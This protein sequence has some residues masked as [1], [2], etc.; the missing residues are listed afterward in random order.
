MLYFPSQQSPHVQSNRKAL[1]PYRYQFPFFTLLSSGHCTTK[2]G[3]LPLNAH[4]TKYAHMQ[5]LSGLRSAA[6]ILS[7]LLALLSLA[8]TPS[9]ADDVGSTPPAAGVATK[10]PF[11]SFGYL[12]EY[13]LGGFNYSAAFRTGGLTHLIFFSIEV[14]PETHEP[15]ALDR[16]PSREQAA[17]ARR[18][19]D[20]VGGKLLLGFGGNS[21]SLGFA[22]M[23]E[24]SARRLKFIQATNHL[25]TTYGFDGVDYNWEYPASA[26]EWRLWGKLM[27]E[28]KRYLLGGAEA[29]VVTFTMYQDP[30]HAEVIRRF[31]LLRHADY[32]HCM[33][34]DQRG[35]H[36]T[37]EFGKEGIE[38]G[39]T[40]LGG[41][42]ATAAKFTL[43]VPFYARHVETGEP[44]TY[45]E[46]ASGVKSR[47]TNQIGKYYFNSQ[48][49]I[50]TKTRLAMEA[51]LGG[52]MIWELGQDLQPCDSKK[53]LL[54]GVA[55]AVT[56]KTA[57]ELR[58]GAGAAGA[59]AD[60]GAAAAE[61]GAAA[62]SDR[63]DEL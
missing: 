8:A 46:L 38:M 49:L 55:E 3:S 41:G 29:N 61:G 23:V 17:E 43:G 16:L 45:G 19:A 47:K 36:S 59:S 39:L 24:N 26:R 4:A 50:F 30:R 37:L 51:G 5:S 27:E 18:A 7:L 10:R 28:S 1:L 33:S 21:R 60:G 42:L 62:K 9:F 44:K 35:R 40:Q 14:D 58:A 2:Y 12:P 54:W 63:S 22:E 56:G 31:D 6:F 13:R 34:Y 25:L 20:A 52:V 48:Q 32:V 53:S 11:A 57:A 15:K